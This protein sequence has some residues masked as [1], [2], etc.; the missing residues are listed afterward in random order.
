MKNDD[1]REKAFHNEFCE[2][3]N[4][5]SNEIFFTP[6][7][8]SLMHL[9]Q[10]NKNDIHNEINTKMNISQLN[11]YYS[12]NNNQT[13]FSSPELL[14][15]LMPFIQF[16]QNDIN[17]YP[18]TDYQFNNTNS[19]SNTTFQLTLFNTQPS[20]NIITNIDIQMNYSPL[21][22]KIM[23]QFRDK[24]YPLLKKFFMDFA[25]K[26]I[27]DEPIQ[28]A[29]IDLEKTSIFDYDLGC[30]SLPTDTEKF[31]YKVYNLFDNLKSITRILKL[32][33]IIY[34]KINLLM[35]CTKRELYYENVDLFRSTDIIDNIE[36]DLCSI[37]G[38]CRFDLPIFPSAKGLFCGNITLVNKFGN[39]LNINTTDMNNKINLIN[40]EFLID[41]FYLDDNTKKNINLVQNDININC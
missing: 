34:N 3:D 20:N 29:V 5:N 21:I 33:L 16:N 24:L 2:F 31:K 40:Y 15:P 1:Y 41:D 32:A 25:Q 36:S 37:L 39:K 28:I 18:S 7:S 4:F 35:P 38:I 13:N 19:N 17:F 30:Y 9:N 6:S 26:L 12:S 22:S 10:D 11:P 23:L 14:K 27:N 8:Y